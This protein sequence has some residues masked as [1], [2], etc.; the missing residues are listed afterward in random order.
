M[1]IEVRTLSIEPLRQTFDHLVRRFGDKPAS[2]YQEG[3]YDIQAAENLHYRP[4]W[5]PGQALYDPGISRIA[6]RDWYALRDPRQYYYSTYTLARAR[7]QD[8]AEA[9]FGFV[10]SRGLAGRVPAEVR[11]LA[12]R[13]LVPLRHAAWGG[14]MNNSFICGYGFGT[15]FTQPCMYYAMDLLGIAQYLTRLGLVLGGPEDLAAGKRAWM[16]DDDWQPLRRY[17]EDCLVVRDPFE[18]FVAQNA[19]LDGQLYPLIYDR[20]VDGWLSE[21]GGSSVALLTQFMS[22]WFAETRKWVDA[23]LKVA[24][25]ESGANRQTLRDWLGHWS[26]RADEALA[27]IAGMAFGGEAATARAATLDAFNA[28]MDA[29]GL[30]AGTVAPAASGPTN[31]ERMRR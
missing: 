6:M 5:D 29:L 13:V 3:S 8:T 28:R 9:N 20:F 18:L 22:E 15:T 16:D 27:P 23:V 24:A 19:A 25:E 10:E 4:T 12:L 26:A 11:D 1:T 21:R 17:A 2:R 7:Q 30:A 14:N 31:Q